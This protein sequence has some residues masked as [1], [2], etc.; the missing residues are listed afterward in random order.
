M[1]AV[2]ACVLGGAIAIDQVKTK[3]R[4]VAAVRS[5]L[6]WEKSQQRSEALVASGK[7]AIAESQTARHDYQRI[8][9]ASDEIAV[10]KARID[11]IKLQNPRTIEE[12]AQQGLDLADMVKRLGAAQKR[13]SE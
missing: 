4:E 11:E 10:M 7:K 13:M 12:R 5:D 8:K 3:S 2:T 1:A 6:E 9:A